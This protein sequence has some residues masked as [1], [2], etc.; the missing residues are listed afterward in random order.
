MSPRQDD[1]LPLLKQ[2]LDAPPEVREVRADD[3]RIVRIAREPE[4]GVDLCLTEVESADSDPLAKCILIAPIESR[5][6]MYPDDLPFVANIPATV[7]SQGDALVVSWQHQAEG[8][9]PF[10]LDI[11]FLYRQLLQGSMDQGWVEAPT[12]E[13][14]P[15]GAEMAVFEREGAQRTV[16]LAKTPRMVSLFQLSDP[17]PEAGA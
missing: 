14:P 17:E 16:S 13:E 8:S 2:A 5:P 7:Y 11:E 4:P 6:E 1:W 9:T 3:G 12:D 10:P 15:A